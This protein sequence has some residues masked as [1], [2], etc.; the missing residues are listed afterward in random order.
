MN[1]EN[2]TFLGKPEIRVLSDGDRKAL[3]KRLD[4]SMSRYMKEADKE[5]YAVGQNWALNTAEYNELEGFIVTDIANLDILLLDGNDYGMKL[6]YNV[7]HHLLGMDFSHD[8]AV[9]IKKEMFGDV[10]RIY[11]EHFVL[12]FIHGVRCKYWEVRDV[13]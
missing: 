7:A 4:A 10:D 2:M 8:E 5:G 6:A 9:V 13:I 11:S 12:S 3:I 1:K